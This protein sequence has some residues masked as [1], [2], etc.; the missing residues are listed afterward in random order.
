MSRKKEAARQ[1][2]WKTHLLRTSVPLE[3]EAARILTAHNFSVSAD[4]AYSRFDGA[5]QKEFTVDVR[6]ITSFDIEGSLLRQCMLDVLVECKYRVDGTR[7]LF[8]PRPSSTTEGLHNV[9]Q[10]VDV[11]SPWH[12][13]DQWWHDAASTAEICYAGVEVGTTS[14]YDEAPQKARAFESQLRH[15]ARQLQYALPPLLAHRARW[16]ALQDPDGNLP[17]FIVPVLVTNVPLIVAHHDFGID[18]VKAMRDLDELGQP[19]PY[20]IWSAGVGPDFDVHCQRELRILSSIAIGTNMKVVE[21]RRRAAG[22]PGWLLPTGIASLIAMDGSHTNKLAEFKK[23][24]VTSVTHLGEVADI[25]RKAVARMC[26]SLKE[27][28]VVK[29]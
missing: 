25:I 18:T 19:V 28:P 5:L 26:R 11:L 7:W 8:L 2:D 17:F 24:I 4:Y 12:V 16:V 27:N 3:H 29:W 14:S 1:S 13:H 21:E 15:G 20:L 9:I 23:I 22:V 6:A 10:A